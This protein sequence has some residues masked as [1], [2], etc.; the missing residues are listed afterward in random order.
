ML[1]GCPPTHVSRYSYMC[2][3]YA[4]ISE[5]ALRFYMYVDKNSRNITDY[6][7]IVNFDSHEFGFKG[8]L[9]H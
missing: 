9:A 1:Q 6:M 8:V 3:K 4:L 5:G 7:G 2:L